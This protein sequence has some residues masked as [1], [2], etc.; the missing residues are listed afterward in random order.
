MD[1]AERMVIAA[2]SLLEWL[3]FASTKLY[4]HCA[5]LRRK[6]ASA[7]AIWI[8]HPH[9]RFLSARDGRPSLACQACNLPAAPKAP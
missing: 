7:A 4:E 5:R 9:R 6:R 2:L 1:F 3:E 8:N